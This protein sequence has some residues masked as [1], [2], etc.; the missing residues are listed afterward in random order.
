MATLHAAAL[1]T[2]S[3]AGDTE[4]DPY[5]LISILG[6]GRTPPVFTC[7]PLVTSAFISMKRSA[8]AHWVDL[9]LQP[10]DSVQLLVSVLEGKQVRLSDETQAAASSTKTLGQHPSTAPPPSPGPRSGDSARRSLDRLGGS[11]HN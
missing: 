4:D 11:S 10:G 3:G 9:S 1:T 5:L 7:R 2:P 6:P 8:R